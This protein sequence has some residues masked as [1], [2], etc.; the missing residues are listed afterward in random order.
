MPPYSAGVSGDC[1]SICYAVLP[2]KKI[3][4]YE[5]EILHCRG[6]KLMLKTLPHCVHILLIQLTNILSLVRRAK[7]HFSKNIYTLNIYLPCE[8]EKQKCH[9]E[10]THKRF[11]RKKI[12][13]FDVQSLNPLLITREI[14]GVALVNCAISHIFT[15]IK[16]E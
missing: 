11:R 6:S 15:I 3:L 1:G 8:F 4:L 9:S 14:T 10:K 7:C 5:L 2:A 16:I 12:G 13:D